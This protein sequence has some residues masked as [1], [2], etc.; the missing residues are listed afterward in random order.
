M[1]IFAFS[2]SSP[3]MSR[4]LPFFRARTP[5]T[6]PCPRAL[7]PTAIYGVKGAWHEHPI[8]TLH[9][10]FGQ[11]ALPVGLAAMGGQGARSA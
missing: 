5:K 7:W 8:P 3:A 1:T 10:R 11:K 4:W 9:W 6:L 2:K